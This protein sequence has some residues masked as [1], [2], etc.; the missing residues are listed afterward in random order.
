M[1]QVPYLKYLNILFKIKGQN[2]DKYW[3]V[4]DMRVYNML[5]IPKIYTE[6]IK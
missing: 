1:F 4:K 5:R 6:N 3:S 2:Q